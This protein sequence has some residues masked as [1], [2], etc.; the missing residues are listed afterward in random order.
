MEK[1]YRAILLVGLALGLAA[2]AHAEL[3]ADYRVI[4]QTEN[5][6][7]FSI[8]PQNKRF[9]RGDDIQGIG[10]DTVRELFKRA[11]ID[12]RMT[13]RSPWSRI[14]GDTLSSPNHGL[15]SVVRTAENRALFKW[16]G[17]L[18]HYDG[19][20]LSAPDKGLRLASLEQAKAY[21]IGVYRNGAL[22]AYLESQGL[23]ADSALNEQENVRKL[24]QGGIDLWATAEP[25]WRY[26]AKQL[27]VAGLETALTF[28]TAELFLALHKDTPDEVVGRLQTAMNEIIAEGY[29]G[30]SKTPEFCYLI[31][32][33]AIPSGS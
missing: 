14:Y 15:F 22:N 29:A 9:A 3:P 30:C 23:E 24:L 28:H 25:A 11:G 10:A 32:N 6:P 33:R 20:L 31:R 19:V 26:Y 27:G 12:Y 21:R 17:P 1:L 5:F 13:L 16:V 2:T 7:P 18:A 8:A 4:L